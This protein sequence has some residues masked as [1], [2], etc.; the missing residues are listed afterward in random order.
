MA[1]PITKRAILLNDPQRIPSE[2][3]YAF[4]LATNGRPGPVLLDIPMDVQRENVME[5][6]PI[7]VHECATVTPDEKDILAVRE[8]LLR[9]RK[10]LI[11]AGGGIR[12]SRTTKQ[13]RRLVDRLGIPV[14]HSLMGVDLLPTRHPLNAGMIGSYG[15][16]WSNLTLSDCDCLLVLGSRLDVR[17]TGADTAGF[18]GDREIYHV[19]CESGEVNNRVKGCYSIICDLGP[20]LEF[21]EEM[22][23]PARDHL[24]KNTASWRMEIEDL[25]RKWPDEDE[26]KTVAGINPNVFMHELS[27]KA[28]DISA[29]IADV[30]QHQMWAAQSLELNADQRFLT[31]GGMGSMGFA[32]PAGIGAAIATPDQPVVVIAGDG[33][34]QCNIQELQTVARLGLPI[35]IIVINNHCLGMVR[36]FQESYFKSRY[37]ST[38]WGYSAPDF[39]AVAR[40]YGIPARS[41]SEASDVANACGWL[42]GQEKGPALLQVMVSAG[43]NVY[44]KLAYGRGMSAMEPFEQ[45]TAMEGT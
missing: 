17:Q 15:N 18:K 33:G 21:L 38:M 39:A 29:W 5:D 24:Q 36:Q 3:N 2:M 28:E 41:V 12:S 30:G 37:H 23:S 35:R 32:L 42:H 13:F 16:R 20:A 44:P 34:F 25:R 1:K 43:A 22:L 19:D 31:S 9:A 11:L 40:A 26:I 10:P 7:E 45:P 14:V 8:G 6:L 4:H 27:K